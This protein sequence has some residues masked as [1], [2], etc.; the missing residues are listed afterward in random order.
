MQDRGRQDGRRVRARSEHA[1]EFLQRDGLLQDPEALPAGVLG[2]VQAGE[3]WAAS[4]GQNPAS[5]SRAARA[6][7]FRSA[8][9][10]TDA[11]SASCSSVNPIAMATPFL[12]RGHSLLERHSVC[13]DAIFRWVKNSLTSGQCFLCVFGIDANTTAGVFRPVSI[14]AVAT[15]SPVAFTPDRW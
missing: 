8:N 4:A 9:P 10:R 1:A 5:A 12:G 7:M 15:I 14:T 6:G 2:Q 11:A 3:A 13:Q